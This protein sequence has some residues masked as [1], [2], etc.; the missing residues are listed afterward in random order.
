MSR[1]RLVGFFL[2]VIGSLVLIYVGIQF[3]VLNAKY[4]SANSA[5]ELIGFVSGLSGALLIQTQKKHKIK[6]DLKS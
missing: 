2:F 4:N 1:L 5:L 3:F 6:L